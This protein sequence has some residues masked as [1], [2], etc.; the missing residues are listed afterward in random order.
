M[1][2]LCAWG[3]SIKAL[4]CRQ[5]EKSQSLHDV[6]NAYCHWT[7]TRW[8]GWGAHG[9]ILNYKYLNSS[10]HCLAIGLAVAQV[11]ISWAKPISKTWKVG[12][13]GW[14]CSRMTTKGISKY[15]WLKYRDRA[16]ALSKSAE[17]CFDVVTKWKNSNY[18][19]VACSF[20]LPLNISLYQRDVQRDAE[21]LEQ[22]FYRIYWYSLTH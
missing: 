20:L 5:K 21:M 10:K 18:Q 16:R 22:E 6:F 1:I 14:I 11:S 3:S 8:W 19:Q 7:F 9:R 17:L 15:V 4:T 2:G 13:V 12:G